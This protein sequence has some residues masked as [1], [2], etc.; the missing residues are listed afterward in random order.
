[1]S[2]APAPSETGRS[3]DV[4]RYATVLQGIRPFDESRLSSDE[5]LAAL[6]EA[7]TAFHVD[8]PVR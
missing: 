5:T 1:M 6:D 3:S 7:I 8:K 2:S 4:G